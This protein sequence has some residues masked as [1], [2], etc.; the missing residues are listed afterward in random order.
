MPPF[1]RFSRPR[2][3][4]LRR[5]RPVAAPEL[6]IRSMPV[7]QVRPCSDTRCDPGPIGPTTLKEDEEIRMTRPPGPPGP[8]PLTPEPMLRPAGSSSQ[9]AQSSPRW[10]QR[11]PPRAS[12]GRWSVWRPRSRHHGERSPR[13]PDQE[14]SPGA[15]VRGP[16][17]R[18]PERLPDHESKS[19]NSLPQAPEAMRG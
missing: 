11:P 8:H 1:H 17:D 10:G 19:S 9:H 14:A 5:R 15:W 12:S 16:C 6:L 2:D 7:P 18:R 13:P 3:H 4:S